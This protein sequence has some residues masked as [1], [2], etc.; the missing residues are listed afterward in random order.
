MQKKI[1]VV[2][3]GYWGKN[4]VRV[5]SELK[6][7]VAVSDPDQDLATRYASEYCAENMS[8]DE[9]INDPSIDGVALAVP[10]PLHSPMAVAAMNKSKNVFVEKPIAMNENEAKL[11]LDAASKNKVQLMVGHLLQYH[12]IFME[13]KKF[14]ESGILGNI[15]Y[16]YSNRLSLGKVR[17]EEDVI[18]SFAPHDISMIL[19]IT[20]CEPTYIKAE[21]S[22]ILRKELADTAIL[23]LRFPCGLKAHISVSWLH[24]IKEQKLVL[25]GDKGMAIFDDCKPWSKKLALYRHI[26]NPS[27]PEKI[28]NKSDVEYIQVQETEPLRNECQHFLDVLDNLSKPITDGKEGLRVLN[29]L[30]AASKS[31][32]VR[33]H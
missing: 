32:E 11:M 10:A 24:P 1:A 29:V 28:L 3:C 12:P 30:T 26:V 19:S 21:S 17:S 16:I 2:G 9:I 13:L 27:Q 4:L 14:K 6:A 23:H 25:I 5:F 8:F 20:G 33:S 22:N 18:W 7:L 15:Q 31:L